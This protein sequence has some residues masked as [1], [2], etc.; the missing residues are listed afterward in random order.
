MCTGYSFEV[1]RAVRRFAEGERCE[2]T[3]SLSGGGALGRAPLDH[4]SGSHLEEVLHGGVGDGGGLL[5]RDAAENVEEARH[6]ARLREKE[7]ERG[8]EREK[9]ENIN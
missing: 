8:G 5:G 4:L 6:E 2:R 7:R 1:G 9:G 3:P